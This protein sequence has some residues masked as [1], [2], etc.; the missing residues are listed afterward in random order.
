M[1]TTNEP[2]DGGIGG[3]RDWRTGWKCPSLAMT[4][5][6][7]G[8]WGMRCCAP[9]TP[10][11]RPG[12]Y[13]S[14]QDRPHPSP[15]THLSMLD[16]IYSKYMIIHRASAQLHNINCHS[17]IHMDWSTNTQNG[18]RLIIRSIHCSH[19]VWSRCL[20]YDRTRR[21]RGGERTGGNG[22]TTLPTT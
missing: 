5:M 18:Q 22:G 6:D 2:K 15:W 9:S 11:C 1:T 4:T 14:E 12:N 3:R 17:W 19:N 16:G 13:V 7:R 21:K 20:L 10:R 8:W